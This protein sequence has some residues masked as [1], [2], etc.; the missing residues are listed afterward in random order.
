MK[1]GTSIVLVVLIILAFLGM[2]KGCESGCDG[3]SG[4]QSGGMCRFCGRHTNWTYKG[5][6]YVCYWCDK[7]YYGYKER[8]NLIN[9]GMVI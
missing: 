7:E 3:D 5:G 2:I 4:S 1:N 9:R 8:D 6:S